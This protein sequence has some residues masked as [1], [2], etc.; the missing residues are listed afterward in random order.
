MTKKITIKSEPAKKKGIID[1]YGPFETYDPDYHRSAER[2][3]NGF[4]LV[5]GVLFLAMVI[6]VALS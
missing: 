1:S 4:G 6:G 2:I 3:H 5:V